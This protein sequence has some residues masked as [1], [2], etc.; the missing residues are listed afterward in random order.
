[1]CEDVSGFFPTAGVFK[2]KIIVDDRIVF[3]HLEIRS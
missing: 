3:F 1:V 2:H